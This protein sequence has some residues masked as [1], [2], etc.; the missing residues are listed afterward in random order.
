MGFYVLKEGFDTLL[1]KRGFEKASGR[2]YDG[3]FC[4]DIDAELEL[5]EG[6]KN[7][8]ADLKALLEACREPDLV[9]R[10]A[11]VEKRV[12][13]KSFLTVMAME[14]ML[15]HWDGYCQ[16]RNNYRL[17]F[18]PVSDKAF[19]L[20]HGMDQLFGDADASILDNPSAIVADAVMKN[21][22]W[23]ADYRKKI[24]ELLPLFNAER[25][26]KRVDEVAKRLQPAI[27]TWNADAARAHE[28]AVLGLKSRLEEREKSLKEQKGM[29]DPKPLVFKPDVPVRVTR[30]RTNSECEDASLTTEKGGGVEIFRIATGKSGVCIASYRRGVL[31][32]AGRYRFQALIAAKDVEKLKEEGAPGTG[33]GVRLSGTTRE[34][35]ASGTTDFKPLV[36]E[37][38]V[39]EEAR[40]VELIVEL[41]ASKG[42]I[43][44][45][46]DS[47]TL[48]KLSK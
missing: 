23:R 46:T 45:R 12:D 18:D 8:R 25:L 48:T 24:G 28:A 9:K 3:G 42:Q 38:E 20:P 19:W 32:G 37:F 15:G 36:Y 40:D 47:L 7:D 22:A 17:Y 29:P 35:S 43:A 2:L 21:P 33:G 27:Q 31:L 41:R 1:L 10:W 13:I 16:N 34:N 30:W 4:Q 44:I 6:K 11:R 14:L 5:D 26:K 39:T